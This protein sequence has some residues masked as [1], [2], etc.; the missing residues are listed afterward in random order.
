MKIAITADLHLDPKYTIKEM[1]AEE[2]ARSTYPDDFPD[3]DF[4]HGEPANNLR[5]WLVLEE[6][7]ENC[8]KSRT[9]HLIIAGDLLDKRSLCIG[10]DDL[11]GRYKEITVHII[12]GNHDD[13]LSKKYFSSSLSNVIIYEQLAVT[14]IAGKL[15][16]FIPYRENASAAQELLKIKPQ[17]PVDKEWVLISH[18]ELAAEEYS[19]SSEERKIYFPLTKRDLAA[20]NPNLVVLGH[21]HQPPKQPIYG[22]VFYPGSP[23]ACNRNETGIRSYITIDLDVPLGK[24]NI[25]YNELNRG[26]VYYTQDI[27]VFPLQDE[28]KFVEN[29]LEIILWGIIYDLV[30]SA[31]GTVFSEQIEALMRRRVYLTLNV[32]GVSFEGKDCLGKLVNKYIGDKVLHPVLDTREVDVSEDAQIPLI[33]QELYNNIMETFCSSERFHGYKEKPRY[34]LGE[35]DSDKILLKVEIMGSDPES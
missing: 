9:E 12:P 18:S 34:L 21:I 4:E 32:K 33:T 8:K 29:Q 35:K 17:I 20:L 10:L 7:L 11:F 28:G 23:C 3:T 22:K 25:E 16:V 15:F 2:E 5:R 27:F 30:Q 1:I 19:L 26:L 6:I 14:A 24:E 31:K 13:F